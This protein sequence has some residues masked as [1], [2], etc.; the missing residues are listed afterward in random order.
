MSRGQSPSRTTYRLSNHKY[1]LNW[2]PLSSWMRSRYSN[3]HRS[4][5]RP[6][7]HPCNYCSNST[8]RLGFP[9][10]DSC[11]P[12]L[13]TNDFQC[14]LCNPKCCTPGKVRHIWCNSNSDHHRS[15]LK[16][17]SNRHFCCPQHRRHKSIQCPS[18][19]SNGLSRSCRRFV[20][21]QSNAAG[22]DTS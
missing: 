22:R 8:H 13:I 2:M 16:G 14:S 18:S 15:T 5:V 11:K 10:S 7:S 19:S 4:G 20:H 21:C 1:R 12:C 3:S 9:R 17:R 6:R